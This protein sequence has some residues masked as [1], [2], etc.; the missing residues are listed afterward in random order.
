[1]ASVEFDSVT[2]SV[3]GT[4]VLR[5]VSLDIADGEFVGV[6]GASG[7][8]KTTLIRTIAGLTDVVRGRV[9]LDGL[10]VTRTKTA[11]RDVGM[12]FQEPV[13]YRNRSV[14]GN[15]SFPL[16][17]RRQE[18]EEIRDRVDAEVRAMHLEHLLSRKPRE[19][20]RGEAQLVQIAR[21][22]VR[23]PRVLLL[24]EPLASLDTARQAQ[25]RS[26]LALLQAGYGVTTL[27]ATNDPLD[28]MTMPSRLV[29]I[30]E[31]RVAQVDRP[32]VVHRM[33]VSLDAAVGTGECWLL[34]AKVS[35]DGEGFW[36]DVGHR[37]DAKGTGIAFRHRAWTPAL[38]DHIGTQVTLGIRPA[39]VVVSPTGPITANVTKIVPGVP[40]GAYCDVGGWRCGLTLP[41]GVREGDVV[42][43]Q[44]G[45]LVVFDQA[46]GRAI[47]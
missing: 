35:A 10:D 33:P 28:A 6:I 22:M 23:T 39:D 15:V 8:G 42:R 18:P 5:D 46:T 11:D 21:A 37:A 1:M 13:M 7:S 9:L 3:D 24:D 38:A 44:V 19:L 31:G 4:V 30:H 27:M 32:D 47:T 45:H 36:L 20:S 16:E 29:V 14:R 25:M 26:E 41:A 43:V 17:L 2:I 34:P 40:D 12:V